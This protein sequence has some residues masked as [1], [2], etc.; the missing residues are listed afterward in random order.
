MAHLGHPVA[1]DEV[2]GKPLY[3]EGDWADPIGR[4]ALHARV[5]AFTHP[6]TGIVQRFEVNE[7]ES[8][9]RLVRA[10]K[11]PAAPRK[12]G[13]EATVDEATPRRRSS[14]PERPGRSASAGGKRKPHDDD[15]NSRRSDKRES[16]DSLTDLK[17]LP[18]KRSAKQAR[19]VSKF[20]PKK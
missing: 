19:G 16:I 8:F 20:I 9:V 18:G 5:L 4:L 11:K 2:Y 1:G 12:T 3:D 15:R 7:S 17:P 14:R 6:F 13:G 10:G